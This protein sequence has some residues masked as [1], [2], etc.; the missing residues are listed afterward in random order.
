MKATDTG[1]DKLIEKAKAGDEEAFLALMRRYESTVYNFSFKVCRDKEKAVDTVQD[2][3]INVFQKLKQFD[4]QSKFSTW[5]YSIVSNNCLM[6]RRRGK[7]AKA[8]VSFEEQ[9]KDDDEFHPPPPVEWKVTPLDETLSKELRRELD[10]AILKLPVEYRIVF[11]LRDIEGKS[12]E[13]SAKI[14]HL[15]VPAVKSRLRRARVFLREQ[16]NGYM[17]S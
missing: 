4:K 7:M 12:A 16:L 8:L 5:L 6:K 10:A 3:F 11:I 2:T 17:T 13:E 9:F 14:L 15:S 1:E